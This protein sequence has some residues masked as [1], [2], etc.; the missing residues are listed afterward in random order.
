MRGR[1]GALAS[2]CLLIA[3]IR[4]YEVHW[5]LA[6]FLFCPNYVTTHVY[7]CTCANWD[8]CPALQLC[9]SSGHASITNTHSRFAVLCQQIPSQWIKQFGLFKTCQLQLML[10]QCCQTEP[11]THSQKLSE[12]CLVSAF[13]QS[14]SNFKFNS[15]RVFNSYFTVIQTALYVVYVIHLIN[16][17]GKVAWWSLFFCNPKVA[18]SS[19]GC[20]IQ[21]KKKNCFLFSFSHYDHPRKEQPKEHTQQHRSIFVQ[22]IVLFFF[23][24]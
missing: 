22:L 24:F 16:G 6:H 9:C 17:G 11:H 3:R 20:I 18:G 12:H 7:V 2:Y 15:R 19:P 10:C 1:V 21:S 23:Y 5:C 13:Y 14:V 8:T 4:E